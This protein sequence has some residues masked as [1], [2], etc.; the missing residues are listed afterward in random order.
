MN[1]QEINNFWHKILDSRYKKAD[2]PQGQA[3]DAWKVKILTQKDFNSLA[4]K[5]N[6][7]S[8][9]QL[10]YL[11]HFGLLAPTS[12]NSSPERFRI[13]PDKNI[14][15]VLV[16][17]KYILTNSDPS[18]RQA[19]ISVGC[20]VANIK[21]AALCYGLKTKLK[22][23]QVSKNDLSPNKNRESKYI[24]LLSIQ[25]QTSTILP[26]LK[27][28]KAMKERKVIRAEYNDKVKISPSFVKELIAHVK[29]NYSR[30]EFKLI[31]KKEELH[32]AGKLQEDADRT[33]FED[34]SFSYELGEWILP[35]QDQTKSVGLRGQ[36]LGFNDNFTQ[37]IRKGLMSEVI[38]PAD[39]MAQFARGGRI[40]IE[41]SSGLGVIS[42]EKDDVEDWILCG[43]VLEELA[44]MLHLK[45]FYTSIH[46]GIAESDWVNS[47]FAS[48]VIHTT[49][50]PTVL[51]RIGVPKRPIDL[52]RPHSSR[53]T[54]ESMILS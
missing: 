23:F 19:C 40:G 48:S 32:L 44:L 10:L 18:G 38:L 43:I 50:R 53:P 49:K 9:E 47:I 29:T 34:P 51:F 33:V 22:F 2:L 4:L 21:S 30:L 1:S 27:F 15:Q 16:D 3:F 54:L 12:H 39:Q 8:A 28:L 41:S 17:R 52:N 42:V 36:E 11:C 45:K 7:I 25:L 13:F 31:I 14:I 35:N 24:H 46:A 5:K 26:D 37:Y 6:E 20:V